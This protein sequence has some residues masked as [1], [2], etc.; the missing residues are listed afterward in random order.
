M[1]N[2]MMS[3]KAIGTKDQKA[4][5]TSAISSVSIIVPCY[6]EQATLETLIGRVLGADTCGLKIEL[7]IV[8]DCSSD[9]SFEIA[10]QLA[11]LEPRI[12][13][14]RHTVN[15]G[16]GAA[17]KTGF[18]ISTGDI[19]MVQDADL[20]YDPDEY[21]LLF[22]PIL[23]G[24]ADVIYG[25]RFKNE[26]PPGAKYMRHVLANKFLTLL[27]N[28]FTGLKLSDMET[29][30]K[31]FKGDV[32][33]AI[34]LTENRFGIEPEMTAKIAAHHPALLISEVAISYKGRTYEEGKKIG[35][36]DGI[37]AIRC[38]VE[39]NLFTKSRK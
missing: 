10:S 39:Y 13:A 22:A 9:K 23:N 6:N 34:E 3:T 35:W 1:M 38:I 30:Y 31:V 8:D 28:I 27:S 17:L 12:K 32:I 5:S 29:C 4:V 15:A 2:M 19:V 11:E 14:V 18:K 25:S 21:P 20:E 24:S 36:K 7:I 33:R 16:K 37:S 26:L